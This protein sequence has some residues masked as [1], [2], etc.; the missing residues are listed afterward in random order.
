[1]LTEERCFHQHV[2]HRLML[3]S[4]PLTSRP[5]SNLV[6]LS[7]AYQEAS[8]PQRWDFFFSQNI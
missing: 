1:M 6:S 3:L 2:S 5:L 8:L 4:S 7:D